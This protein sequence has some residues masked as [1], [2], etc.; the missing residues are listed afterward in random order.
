MKL[1]NKIIFGALSLGAIGVSIYFYNKSKKTP[2]VLNKT[3]RGD[4]VVESEELDDSKFPLQNGS[5]GAE[6]K[7]LQEYLN[8]SASC[9]KKA[10]T[11]SAN[12][13]MR[14]FLPLDVDGIFGGNTEYVLT[15]C[16]KT[17]SINKDTF[18]KMKLSINNK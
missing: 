1:S 18:R 13:R 5:K 12:A 15:T 6:V 2:V 14:P 8:R 17:N 3:T 7:L 11:P 4:E 10:P 16:Y 9:M